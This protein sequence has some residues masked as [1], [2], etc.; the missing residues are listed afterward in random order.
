MK[1]AK[2]QSAPAKSHLVSFKDSPVA[3]DH[4]VRHKEIPYRPVDQS[5][6][7]SLAEDIAANGL[8]T[9]I[10]VFA[11]SEDQ[12]LKV[13]GNTVPANF[14]AAGLH[15]TEALKLVR[16]N[17]PEAFKKHFPEGVIPSRRAIAQPQDMIF[18]MLR[19]NVQRRDMTSEEIFPV[20]EKLSAEPYNLSTGEI[21]KKI[22]KSKGWVSQHMAVNEELPEDVKKDVHEGKIAVGDARKLATETRAARNKGEKIS[23]DTVREK[24]SALKEKKAHKDAAGNQRAA[25]DDRRLGAKSIF[26]RVQ[27]LPKLTMGRELE[28]LRGAISYLAGES[29]KLP[30]E[31]RKEPKPAAKEEKKAD[32]KPEAK[33]GDKKAKK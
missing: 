12:K 22:G 16:R 1:V 4:I 10:L 24:A 19:E 6:V 20:L 13:G 5:H 26:Q 17:H 21:A 9:P 15:R 32:K 33:K 7:E 11:A 28:V 27:A 18:A 29:D 23:E 31:L 3:L 8:M 2:E 14:L 25:G 30:A